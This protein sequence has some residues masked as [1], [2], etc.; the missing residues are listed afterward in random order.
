MQISDE[1]MNTLKSVILELNTFDTEEKRL[2]YLQKNV[3]NVDLFID[4][5]KCVNKS[6][7]KVVKAKSQ[8][9]KEA[10][11][12]TYCSQEVVDLFEKVRVEDILKKYSKTEL[13]KMYEVIYN[14][15]PLSADNKERIAETIKQYVYA[16]NRTDALLG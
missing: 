10:V 11:V 5:L 7:L 14:T 3:E 12:N 15:K 9:K 4:T 13:L 8:S 2:H 1:Q 6:K 16:K